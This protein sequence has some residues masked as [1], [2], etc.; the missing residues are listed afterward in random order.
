MNERPLSADE[1]LARC[2]RAF[3]EWLLQHQIDTLRK[4]ERDWF[5]GMVIVLSLTFV[6]AAL[7]IFTVIARLPS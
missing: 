2:D 4:A 6:G 1:Q 7:G 3:K 5:I